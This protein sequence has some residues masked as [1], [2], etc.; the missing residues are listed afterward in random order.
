MCTVV[1][2]AHLP[3]RAYS[4]S[5]MSGPLP[6]L[7]DETFRRVLCV[8]AHPDDIEYGSSAAVA[9]WTAA[10]AEVR[11]LML[12]HGEAGMDS[13]PPA[14][15]SRIRTAEQIAA[16]AAVGVTDVTFL[17]HPDG[18][19]VESPALR[20]DISRVIRRFRP[21]VVLTG[22]W[23][24]EFVAGLNQADHRVAGIATLDAVRDAGNR[25]VFPELLDEDLPPWAVTWFL[26]AGHT[27]PNYAVDVTGAALEAGIASLEAHGEYLGDLPGHPTARQML[28]MI[29]G[30][31]GRAA[32]VES[33]TLFR[34][35]NFS[36][37]PKMDAGPPPVS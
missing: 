37:P 29:A 3:I 31:Q 25:W 27:R 8:A 13:T 22:T 24:V 16:G 6:F 23:E 35:W 26:V 33:A 21:D 19:M 5:V 12:S 32:G 34:A 4:P 10:G 17:D 9:R 2:A 30:M 1:R 14:E 18:V 7:P 36:E 15:T 28:S 11:Y 20:R